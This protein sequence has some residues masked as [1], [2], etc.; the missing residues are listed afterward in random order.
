MFRC[1]ATICSWKV[2]HRRARGSGNNALFVFSTVACFT[3]VNISASLY[4]LLREKWLNEH[5]IHFFISVFAGD[6]EKKPV[7]AWYTHKNPNI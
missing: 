6:L 1:G 4:S 3:R 5:Y 7:G 2:Y